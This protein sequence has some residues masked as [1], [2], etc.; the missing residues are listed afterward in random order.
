MTQYNMKHGLMCSG[1]SGVSA[2]EDD[3]SNDNDNATITLNPAGPD[4]YGPIAGVSIDQGYN[5]VDTDAAGKETA[6]T[7]PTGVAELTVVA[8]T[9]GVADYAEE[10]IKQEDKK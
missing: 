2:I 10:Y 8:D 5:V 4:H 6:E 3:N 7:E 1:Q 9:T